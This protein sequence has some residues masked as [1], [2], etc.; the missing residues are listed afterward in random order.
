MTEQVST[1]RTKNALLNKNVLFATALFAGLSPGVLLTI[2]SE[3]K[4]MWMSGQTSPTAVFVHAGVFGVSF[5]L[6]RAWMKSSRKTP[7][8]V[9]K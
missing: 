2:P 5:A 6:A 8:L 4:G 7:E 3:S 1:E 9:R